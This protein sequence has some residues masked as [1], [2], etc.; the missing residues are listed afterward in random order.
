MDR[1]RD[2]YSR[3]LGSTPSKDVI[4][5]IDFLKN[6][7]YNICIKKNKRGKEN[8]G[9]DIEYGIKRICKKNGTGKKKKR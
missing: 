7:C 1:A 4:T 9:N 6:F 2:F 8:N 5:K 3:N